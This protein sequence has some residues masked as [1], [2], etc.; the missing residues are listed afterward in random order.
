MLVGDRNSL[1]F[2]DLYFLCIVLGRNVRIQ[3]CDIV[4]YEQQWM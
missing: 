4:L 2:R 1:L 3:Y